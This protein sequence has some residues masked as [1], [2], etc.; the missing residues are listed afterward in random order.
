MSERDSEEKFSTGIGN[1]KCRIRYLL[2]YLVVTTSSSL[3]YTFG[4]EFTDY[5]FLVSTLF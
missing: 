1:S 5:F 3:G 4:L 2:D